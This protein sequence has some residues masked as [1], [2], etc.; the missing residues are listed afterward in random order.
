[1]PILDKFGII[2][3]GGPDLIAPTITNVTV[4]NT[5]ATIGTVSFNLTNNM[6]EPARIFY[7]TSTPPTSTFVDLGANATSGTLTIS[8]LN[9]GTSYVLYARTDFDG[10]LTE[11][12]SA[13]FTTLTISYSISFSPT[14]INEGASTTATVSTTNFG[15]GTL[16]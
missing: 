2:T 10:E 8:G 5:F 4:G 15:S 6:E 14:S 11:I 16:F 13:N 1:M 7:G 9:Q 12:V 3:A